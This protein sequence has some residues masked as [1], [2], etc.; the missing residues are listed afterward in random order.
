[1]T[2]HPRPPRACARR[3]FRVSAWIGAFLS[4]PFAASAATEGHNSFLAPLL[5]ESWR[6]ALYARANWGEL[7]V[8]PN[9]ILVLVV[10]ILTMLW[11]ARRLNPLPVTRSQNFIEWLVDGL[12]KQFSPVLG[13]AGRKYLPLIESFFVFILV[14][15]LSG[16]VPAF[17]A[18]TAELNTTIALA[19]VS[20]VLV[21]FIAIKEL[22]P[23]G[24]FMHLW[25]RPVWLGILMFPIEAITQGARVVSLSL[26]LFANIYAKEVV[27]GALFVLATQVFY[28][29]VQLPVL[30]IGLL[31]SLIQA[32]IFSILTAVYIGQ[33]LEH[34][35]SH[36]DHE[37]GDHAAQAH[38]A[39]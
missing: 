23:W 33:F 13:P 38:A 25:G 9:T 14:A 31:A 5:P 1:M 10:I 19:V 7:D 17:Q 12:D 29:P 6:R 11:L 2:D 27:L 20:I 8:I 35:H 37:H 26:R 16:F 4:I 39:H 15:N 3:A 22:G 18:P 32:F 34:A 36:G 30:F 24:Y 21:Q 28:I